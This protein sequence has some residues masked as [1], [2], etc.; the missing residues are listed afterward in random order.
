MV[1]GVCLLYVKWEE[2]G[3]KG[4]KK[5]AITCS[6]QRGVAIGAGIG[7]SLS[8]TDRCSGRQ[9]LW[10]LQ[11]HKEGQPAAEILQERRD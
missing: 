10:L 7:F 6:V 1:M 4:K 2:R 3:K 11:T 8:H 9:L 5:F